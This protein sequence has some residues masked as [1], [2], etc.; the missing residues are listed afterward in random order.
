MSVENHVGDFIAGQPVTISFTDAQNCNA[1][2]ACLWDDWIG[3]Y[4]VTENPDWTSYQDGHWAYHGSG[5]V[6]SGSVT[7]TPAEFGDYFV[8]LLGGA[9]GYTELTDPDNRLIISVVNWVPLA[10]PIITVG[11]CRTTA[12]SH[13]CDLLFGA[14]ILTC[15]A[16]LAK[17]RGARRQALLDTEQHGFC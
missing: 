8:V 7:I 17:S 3:I 15:C 5:D 9:D 1:D 2:G 6:G 12:G 11:D 10:E 13:G 14:V 16:P 4:P